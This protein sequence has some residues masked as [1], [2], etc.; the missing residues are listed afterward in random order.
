M[1]DSKL[2]LIAPTLTDH[3]VDVGL[4]TEAAILSQFVRRG[5]SVLLPIGVNHRYD[6]LLDLDGTFV[7]AQCKT[8]RL[9]NGVVEFAPRSTRANRRQIF[10]RGYRGEIEIFLVYCRELDRIYAVPVDEAPRTQMLTRRSRPE[11]PEPRNT[12]G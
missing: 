2:V 7:R 3:P 5:F 6:L 1:P 10:N 4:Q 8:G 9:R 12:F 11:R